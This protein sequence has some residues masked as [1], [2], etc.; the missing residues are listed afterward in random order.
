[1]TQVLPG[2]FH[3]FA[4]RHALAL[5]QPGDDRADCFQRPAVAQPTERLGILEL[6]FLGGCTRQCVGQ[7]CVGL[8][9]L[10]ADEQFAGQPADGKAGLR[11]ER[12]QPGEEEGPLWR[13]RWALADQGELNNPER[14]GQGGR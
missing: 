14:F 4:P 12:L 2:G 7:P 1:M 6:L 9:A 5:L 10:E 3:Q 11:V 13:R 8:L